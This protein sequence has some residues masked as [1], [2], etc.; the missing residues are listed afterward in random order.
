MK[1]TPFTPFLLLVFLMVSLINSRCSPPAA[2]VDSGQNTCG[3]QQTVSTVKN[4]NT[5]GTS[6]T[7]YA[8]DA[9]DNL[10]RIAKTSWYQSGT[11]ATYCPETFRF[12]M[13][14]L[15]GETF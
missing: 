2:G 4:A 14:Y 10:L 12:R 8:Y 9:A 13:A 5:E 11:M 15:N 3:I 6:Q 1:T 7:Q